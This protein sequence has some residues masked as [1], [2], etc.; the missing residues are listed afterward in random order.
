MKVHADVLRATLPEGVIVG[1][2]Q[3][4]SQLLD[5]RFDL[6]VENADRSILVLGVLTLFLQ[7]RLAS[8]VA[9]GIPISFGAI[10]MMPT[11]DIS[12]NMIS[13]FA[14][15]IALGLVVDDAIIV[16]ENI[17]ERTLKHGISVRTSI[18]GAQQMIVLVTF[19]IIT[20]M[21]AFAPMLFV[22]G[23]SGKLFRIL[24]LIVIWCSFSPSSPS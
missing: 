11:T 2:W 13:L 24:P 9:L 7:L 12:L 6:L 15:I 16:G 20:T 4:D 21:A 18:E 22:L 17:Y 1:T 19:S 10:F 3:D 5:E 8:W 14:F 23:V